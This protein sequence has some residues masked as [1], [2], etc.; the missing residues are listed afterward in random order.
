MSGKS[1]AFPNNFSPNTSSSVEKIK[2]LSK[3]LSRN[4][5]LLGI[6]L[7]ITAFFGYLLYTNISSIVNAYK[8]YKYNKDAKS[9]VTM[10]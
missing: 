7:I 10:A 2:E 5:L 4:W 3:S 6:F 9:A 1:C 8:E